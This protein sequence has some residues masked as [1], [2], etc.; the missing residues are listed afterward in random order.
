MAR[1]GTIRGTGAA[2]RIRRPRL[3]A[4]LAP[5]LS[6]SV[7]AVIIGHAPSPSPHPVGDLASLTASSPAVVAGC[8]GK[9]LVRPPTIML[10]CDDGNA[11]L[12]GL[13]W[14][15]WQSSATGTGTWRINDCIPTCATGTFRSF[16]A[17]VKLWRPEPLP[18]HAGTDYY[19]KI[20]ITLPD[21]HCYVAGGRR[22]CYP[23]RYTG[24]LRST[25]VSRP[26]P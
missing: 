18:R 16:A 15:T 12:S 17:T 13:R 21:G 25:P 10:A 11:Y 5:I 19:S 2:V 24:T 4:A 26:A 1:G 7:A 22:G 23:A 3:A 20:T 9:P 8:A 14:A 6:G